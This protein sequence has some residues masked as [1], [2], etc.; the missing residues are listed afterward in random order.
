MAA[1]HYSV[2]FG[3]DSADSA[4]VEVVEKGDGSLAVEVD[5]RPVEVDFVAIGRRLNVRVDARVVDLTA[6]RWAAGSEV[7][8]AGRHTALAVESERS[9]GAD[10][11]RAA[12]G[13]GAKGAVIRS[14]M[15][16]RVVRILVAP[17]D[18]VQAGQGVAVLEAMKMENE[19]R[20]RGEGKVLEVH[21]AIG[22]AVEANAKLVT[23]GAA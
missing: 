4:S 18:T 9:R 1:V 14:P 7:V 3:S 5:G 15:P 19:V 16:G 20:S 11:A 22:A 23:M 13:G 6:Q 2:S 12:L 10:A 8:V 17:G 21:V